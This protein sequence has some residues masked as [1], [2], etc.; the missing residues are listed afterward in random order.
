L[1]KLELSNTDAAGKQ[2][3]R[4]LLFKLIKELNTV[5]NLNKEGDEV[6]STIYDEEGEEFDDV[7]G[8]CLLI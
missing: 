8:N 3:Y 2:N 6:D 1:K 4:E 7:E 5:D